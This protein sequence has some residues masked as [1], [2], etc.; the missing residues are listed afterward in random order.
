VRRRALHL[1]IFRKALRALGIRGKRRLGYQLALVEE[2]AVP[3]PAAPAVETDVDVDVDD[4][5]VDGL[6]V[7]DVEAVLL[8]EEGLRRA[9]PTRAKVWER[10]GLRLYGELLAPFAGR[11]LNAF[12]LPFEATDEASELRQELEVLQKQILTDPLGAA[13]KLAV[14]KLPSFGKKTQTK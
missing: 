7:P 5:D 8:I 6:E 1:D 13:A 14:A 9:F 4:V 3:E 2:P 11:A 10:Y 12:V